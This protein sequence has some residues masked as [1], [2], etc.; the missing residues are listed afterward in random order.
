MSSQAPPPPLECCDYRR[1]LPYLVC[2]VLGIQPRAGCKQDNA[3][4]IELPS[5]AHPWFPNRTFQSPCILSVTVPLPGPPVSAPALIPLRR[6]GL[7]PLTCWLRSEPLNRVWG[8]R[9]W[10]FPPELSLGYRQ[11]ERARQNG[12]EY[13]TMPVGLWTCFLVG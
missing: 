13:I 2:V 10:R 1:A 5:S 9:C 3:L 4:P 12:C 11:E 6:F 7:S 8:T